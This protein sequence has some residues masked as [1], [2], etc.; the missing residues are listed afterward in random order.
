MAFP[1]VGG[2]QKKYLKKKGW[3]DQKHDTTLINMGV[4]HFLGEVAVWMSSWIC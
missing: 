4:F 3:N 1:P 2:V